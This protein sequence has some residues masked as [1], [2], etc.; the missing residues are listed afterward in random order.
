MV[1][2]KK[3]VLFFFLI[4]FSFKAI[5]TENEQLELLI[6]AND[7]S[8]KLSQIAI[9]IDNDYQGE[10][11][12]VV[13]IMKG[14]ICVTADLMREIKT[15]ATL[16]YIQASSYG[17]NGKSKGNL[18]L[19]GIE[20]IDLKGKNVLVVDD[21]FDSGTTMTSIVE[22]L[23]EKQ[24]KTIKSLVV[25]QKKIERETAY[26]PDYALFEIDNHFIVGYGLDYKER[27]RGSLTAHLNLIKYDD[28][29]SL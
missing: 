23:K 1:F 15:P 10:D 9:Q 11:L 25:F 16:E 20:K 3:Y 5:S 2:M 27:Y 12:T 7:I 21:I 4:I 14:A 19:I 6:S 13:M 26:R 24:P 18:Q 22:A 8:K 28:T 29:L 17:K